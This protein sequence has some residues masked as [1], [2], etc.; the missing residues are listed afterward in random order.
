LLEARDLDEAGLDSGRIN[1]CTRGKVCEEAILVPLKTRP[2]SP[3]QFGHLRRVQP[4]R[5]NL[6]SNIEI[7]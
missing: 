5:D 4:A 7:T 2:R 1:V 3:P 6:L